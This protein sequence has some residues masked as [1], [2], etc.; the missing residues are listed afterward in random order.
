MR[1]LVIGGGGREHALVWKIRQSPQVKEVF[2]APGNGGIAQLAECVDI[3]VDDLK[4]LRQ[5]ARRKRIDLTVVGPELP[6]TLG[7]V[8]FFQKE[9]LR[10][11][12]PCRAAAAL[13]G[14]KAFAKEIMNTCGIPTAEFATFSDPEEAEA[15]LH[16]KQG[17]FVIKADGLAAGKG[18]IICQSRAEAFEA[19]EKI[20]KEK[21][22]GQAGDKVII[23]EYLRGEEVSVL[24]VTDGI[25][26]VLLPSSQDHKAVF[27]GDRGPNTGGMGAYAPAP[28]MTLSLEETVGERIIRPV[29]QG[30]QKQGIEYR[31]VLY[32][33]L[34]ITA[35]GPKVLEFNCRF[36][37]PE[38]Q[39]VLP[40]LGADLVDVMNAAV[41]G[42]MG[43]VHLQKEKDAAV[44]VV[45]ASG[46]YPGAY[47][48]GK[49]IHGLDDMPSDIVVFHAGT[50]VKGRDIVTSGG[51]VLGVTARGKTIKQA[52]DNAYKAVGGI[53]FDGAYYRRDIAHRAL[54][55]KQPT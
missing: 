21:Q 32:A 5:F 51:R 53:T 37:D 9:G 49:V 22:F 48:K 13:E 46:G 19:V 3:A 29:L 2:C 25:H 28:I 12:G 27:E 33:G 35:G 39:A 15:Y 34:M 18:V 36:G 17:P 54:N 44:C 10:I 45:M 16:K 20:M 11:F 8:D 47:S 26:S 42:R 30:L 1:V 52:V 31:G 41:D 24:A 23:E 55:R 43:E 6:L 50:K 4:G 40:L 14:S 38:T 7:I